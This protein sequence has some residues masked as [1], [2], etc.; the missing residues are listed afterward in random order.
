[1]HYFILQYLIYGLIFFCG[2][3]CFVLTNH[4]K[5]SCLKA[6]WF[7]RISVDTTSFHSSLS[8]RDCIPTLMFTIA[9]ESCYY[10]WV[11]VCKLI[12]A[13]SFYSEAIS[14]VVDKTSGN[15]HRSTKDYEHLFLQYISMSERKTGKGD[16]LEL[17]M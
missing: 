6:V 1:M 7:L 3:F 11:S 2:V 4:N 12:N 9:P 17:F 10:R 15:R 13:L 16:I 14:A 8:Q 5:Q